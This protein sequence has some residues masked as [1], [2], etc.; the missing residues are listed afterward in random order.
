ML[1]RTGAKPLTQRHEDGGARIAVIA[2]HA[3]LDEFV[4]GEG[5]IDFGRD[6]I[7]KAGRADHH[8]RFEGVGARFKRTPIGWRKL[9]R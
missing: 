8:D 6:G 1:Y 5:A 4:M 3:N 9:Q 2:Q 7:G